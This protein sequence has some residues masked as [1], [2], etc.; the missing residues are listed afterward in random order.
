[1]RVSANDII[2]RRVYAYFQDNTIAYI[3]SSYCKLE[4]LEN[5]HRNWREKYGEQGKTFFREN[6][7]EGVFKTLIELYTDQKSIEGLE[8]QLIRALRPKYNKDLNPVKSSIKYER[9]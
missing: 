7:N 2:Q 1:M 9:Y 3:G 6:I 4:T 8:G 5:N